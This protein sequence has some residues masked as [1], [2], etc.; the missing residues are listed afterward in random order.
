MWKKISI[1]WII[2]FIVHL[3]VINYQLMSEYKKLD[4][5]LVEMVSGRPCFAQQKIIL[6]HQTMG[7]NSS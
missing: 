2:W 6:S 3:S 4:D 7:C 5:N 1:K